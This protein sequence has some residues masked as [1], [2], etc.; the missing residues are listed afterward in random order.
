MYR[1]WR[2]DPCP[3]RL[4]RNG[5]DAFLSRYRLDGIAWSCLRVCLGVRF[6]Q[7]EL[8]SVPKDFRIIDGTFAVKQ[9]DD[10]KVLELAGSPL[11]TFGFLFGPAQQDGLG[12]SARIHGTSRGRR[13]PHFA[14]SLGSVGGHRLQVSPAKLAIEIL[15]GDTPQ[16][17]VPYQ[18]KSGTWT[19][20]KF[21]IRKVD[22]KQWKVE[23]KV[24]QDGQPEPD[25]WMI[26][27]DESEAPIPGRPGAWGIPF[28]VTPIRF[29]DL[30]VTPAE[31]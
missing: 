21:Q 11:E 8:D 3:E 14:V 7:A 10:N 24:W 23:G 12:V 31:E 18:W 29:D 17:S 16:T 26:T 13:F 4:Q 20:L 28:S 19:H 22:D 2:D 15:R 9:Q 27:L 30:K 5:G 1:R 25:E 6:E